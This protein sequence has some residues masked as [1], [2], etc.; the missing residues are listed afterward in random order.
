MTELSRLAMVAVAA[1]CCALP[2]FAATHTVAIEGMAFHPATLRVHAGDRIVFVNRDLV[3]HTATA[4]GSFDSATIAPGA[5]WSWQAARRG[6]WAYRCTLHP[7]M[8]ATLV[9]E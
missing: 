5:S 6:T 2:A 1:A 3:P 8:H 9:I 7:T 4:E